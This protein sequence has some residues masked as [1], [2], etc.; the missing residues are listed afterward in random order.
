MKLPALIAHR[1]YAVRYPENSLPGLE[2][3]LRSGVRHLEVDVQLSADGIPV[4]FHDDDL[5]RICDV[6]GAV[7]ECDLAALERLSAGERDRFGARFADNRVARLA[8]LGELLGANP[9]VTSFIEAKQVAIDHFGVDAVLDAIDGVLAPVAARCV[10]ISFSLPLLSRARERAGSMA[11]GAPGYH[12]LGGVVS[13]WR[14][15]HTLGGLGLSYLFCDIEGLPAKGPLAFES[16]RLAVYEVDDARVALDLAARG[17]AF[18]ETF[19]CVGL[20][21]GIRRL[22][23]SGPGAVC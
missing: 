5:K 14:N 11:C 10:L 16:A 12:A 9:G 2:A 7:H 20:S 19:D 23:G 17:V 4:L 15:R 18:V 8:E 13:H 21:D 3:A 6:P 22:A 1:G